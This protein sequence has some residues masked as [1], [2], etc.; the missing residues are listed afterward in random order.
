MRVATRV[1]FWVR[2][3]A[4]RLFGLT[5]GLVLVFSTAPAHELG[6]IRTYATFQKGGEYEVRVFIDREHLPPGFASSSA[7]PRIPIGGLR[8]D[9]GEKAARILSEVL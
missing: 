4:L 8:W 9:S 1:A 6:T 7:P 3:S 2:P 5:A